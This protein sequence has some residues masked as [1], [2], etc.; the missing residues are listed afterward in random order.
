M[1]APQP[2][3][4]DSTHDVRVI[5]RP[6]QVEQLSSREARELGKVAD[7]FAFRATDYY[8]DL[9]DWEDPDD[10]IRRLILPDVR[11][12]QE[13]GDLDPSNEASNTVV[14]GLQHKYGDTALILT[15]DTCTAYCRY[16][17]RKRLFLRHNDEAVPRLDAAFDYVRRNRQITDVLLTGGDPL[18]L[19]TDRLAPTLRRFASLP[20][21][22]TVR[23]GTKTP[24]FNP[25]RI[26]G[27]GTL[28]DVVEEVTQAGTAVYL[29]A[30]FDHPRELTDDA[31][32]AVRAMQSAGAFGVN[33]CPLVRG[34]ND[35]A[36]VLTELFEATTELGIPQYYVFQGR[37]T[38]GN[39]PFQLPIVR[40]W[41]IFQEARSCCS[42][43]SRRAR[44]AMSHAT[45]KVEVV[46]V[47]DRRIYLRYHRAR[48]AQDESRVLI[49]R[50]DDGALWL[51]DLDIAG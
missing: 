38:T 33:Q 23:I 2:R 1:T 10:P 41:E 47:D 25:H 48:D 16:C 14:R 13:A 50:R 17:F 11:E 22:R 36:E 39:G 4:I 49:A 27:D 45:G 26:L 5:R 8:L 29:M 28:L 6:E 30:H 31:C 46:G 51:D 40:G 34:I 32:A 19:P 44:F 12:L 20:H 24:A 18:V 3:K 7:R 37:P 15:A 9:I 42:G 43:L 21:V 35:D